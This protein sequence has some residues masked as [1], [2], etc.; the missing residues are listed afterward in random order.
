M[1]GAQRIWTDV[2]DSYEA[3]SRLAAALQ[4]A[5]RDDFTGKRIVALL[6]DTG[7]RYLSVPGYLV[8]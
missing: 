5:Q 4:L 1:N 3:A 2:A 6:P 8:Q 7:E